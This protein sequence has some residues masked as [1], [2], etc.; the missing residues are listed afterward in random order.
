MGITLSWELFGLVLHA[1]W[2]KLN[3]FKINYYEKKVAFAELIL[4]IC[5]ILKRN[6]KT[7]GFSHAFNDPLSE[8]WRI[9]IS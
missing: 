6:E 2:C 8:M 1:L 9:F 3:D 5:H 4:Y 7:I